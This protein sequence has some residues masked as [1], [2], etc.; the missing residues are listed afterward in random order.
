MHHYP[1]EHMSRYCRRA[2]ELCHRTHE[3]WPP[4][5]LHR[6]KLLVDRTRFCPWFLHHFHLPVHLILIITFQW[7]INIRQCIV[8]LKK[9]KRRTCYR[10]LFHNNRIFLFSLHCDVLRIPP[11]QRSLCFLLRLESGCRCCLSFNHS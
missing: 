10:D 5:M 2:E 7:Y 11:G 4:K 1:G 9:A 3:Q 6:L 8:L